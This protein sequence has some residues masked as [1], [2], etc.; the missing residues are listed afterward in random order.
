MLSVNA[1]ERQRL[2]NVRLQMISRCHNPADAN[3][4]NYGGRGIVVCDRWRN[5]PAAFIDDIGPRPAGLTIDRVDN[6]GNYEP[7]NVRWSSRAEQARNRRNNVEVEI[8]G[9]KANLADVC[10]ARGL[11]Y[12][13]IHKRIVSRGWS[14]A[15]AISIPLTRANRGT[16]RGKV[17]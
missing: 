5:S 16:P 6:D 17:L 14:A 10:A 12:S 7:G 9:V 8:D 1:K 4:A 15:D 13:A 3:F 11:P 2:L